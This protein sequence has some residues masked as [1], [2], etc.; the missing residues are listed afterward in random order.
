LRHPAHARRPPDLGFDGLAF[1]RFWFE[2]FG[3]CHAAVANGIIEREPRKAGYSGFDSALYRKLD[4][5]W[6]FPQ[7]NATLHDLKVSTCESK[8]L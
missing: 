8:P 7:E 3:K 5:K 2:H 4:A 6:R 1:E